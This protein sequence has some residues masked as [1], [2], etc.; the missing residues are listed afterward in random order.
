MLADPVFMAKSHLQV[1]FVSLNHKPKSHFCSEASSAQ[2]A[3]L[4][5]DLGLNIIAD[6]L[7]LID[8]TFLVIH[9]PVRL[10]SLADSNA[11]NCN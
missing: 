6:S 7:H 5:A 8:S 10:Q 3:Q 1:S 4:E 11:F 2:C 9:H